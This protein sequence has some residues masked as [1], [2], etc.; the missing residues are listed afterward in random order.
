MPRRDGTGPMGMGARTGR[1]MGNCSSGVKR[2][3]GLAISAGLGLGLKRGFRNLL[4]LSLTP[5]EEVS[6][7]KS[8]A[9]DLEQGLS[10]IKERINEL[11]NKE[12]E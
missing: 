1:G 9:E 8:K 7:L 10:K 2:G 12:G 11:E 3:L 5:E 6:M 4:R